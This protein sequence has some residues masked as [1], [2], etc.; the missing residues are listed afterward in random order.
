ME[1]NGRQM[2]TDLDNKHAVIHKAH[3]AIGMPLKS[4]IK[5]LLVRY[6]YL[7]SVSVMEGW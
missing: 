3:L 2:Q 7:S 1:M 4:V 6:Q 5:G